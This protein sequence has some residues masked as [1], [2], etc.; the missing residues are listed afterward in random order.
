MVQHVSQ[1]ELSS[2]A[3]V[4]DTPAYHRV[5]R[6]FELPGSLYAIT[7]ACY[8][9]FLAVMGLL[10][11]NAELILPMAAFVISIVGGFGLGYKWVTMKPDHAGE[12]LSSGQFANRGI[13][14]LSGR[15]TAAEASAQVLILPVLLFVWGLVIAAIVAFVPH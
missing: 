9:G 6:S 11:M 2:V 13:Q 3:R 1:A 4:S 12:T 8:L 5:N 10:F 14:T 15:L 7:V